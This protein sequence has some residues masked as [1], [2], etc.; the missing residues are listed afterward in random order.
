MK[1]KYPVTI[2]RPS[3]T[4]LNGEIKHP[5]PITLDEI[6]ITIVDNAKRRHASA[7][8]RTCPR[9]LVLWQGEDYD[10]AGDYT[11]AQAEAR[12]L[13]VLGPDLKAGLEGLFLP[14]ARPTR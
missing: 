7:Q 12:L 10:A 4:G 9:P 6:D 3:Y 5:K 11:Q 1:L 2:Q 14:S 8:I 13:E